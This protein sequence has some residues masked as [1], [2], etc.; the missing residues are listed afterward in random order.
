M[1]EEC[2]WRAMFES[3]HAANHLLAQRLVKLKRENQH[4]QELLSEQQ[5][6][7]DHVESPTKVTASNP[8]PCVT[9]AYIFGSKG[10][11]Y[12]RL[13]S[14][15]V[16]QEQSLQ[17]MCFAANH[18]EPAVTHRTTHEFQDQVFRGQFRG[19]DSNV[20][21][22][23]MAVTRALGSEKQDTQAASIVE[24]HVYCMGFYFEHPLGVKAGKIAC[25]RRCFVVSACLP[26]VRFLLQ[27][28]PFFLQFLGHNHSST[29]SASELP[30]MALH[31]CVSPSASRVNQRRRP[32][33]TDGVLQRAIDGGR[34]QCY[35]PIRSP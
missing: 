23:T 29:G 30:Y 32:G 20:F 19:F 12:F 9:N 17:V 26:L 5:D 18:S 34:N 27:V 28:S 35:P 1:S 31:R 14:G 2:D 6:T 11:T 13:Y 8:I 33:C 25:E 4:L 24:Q 22:T 15:K 3:E 21:C 7:L 16:E 10:S